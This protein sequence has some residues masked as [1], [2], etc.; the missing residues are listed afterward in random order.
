MNGLFEDYASVQM[1]FQSIKWAD[2]CLKC[3]SHPRQCGDYTLSLQILQK[4]VPPLLPG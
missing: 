1:M 3:A 2:A 4:A